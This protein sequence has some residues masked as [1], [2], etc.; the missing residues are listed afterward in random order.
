MDKLT[1]LV[2]SSGGGFLATGWVDGP[3]G[4]SSGWVSPGQAIA[5]HFSDTGD[6]VWATP[7][8]KAG[9]Y[10]FNAVAE[11]SSGGVIV[12]GTTTN[13]NHSLSRGTIPN[14]WDAAIFELGFA[15]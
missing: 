12:A 4:I 9:D 11:T 2:A 8:G 13:V 3:T 10:Q 6:M 5:A 15:D 7:V 14:T 1:S